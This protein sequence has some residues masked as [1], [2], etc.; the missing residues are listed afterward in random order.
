[1]CYSE[2]VNQNNTPKIYVEQ[3]FVLLHK[4]YDI[5]FSITQVCMHMFYS[6]LVLKVWVGPSS[7]EKLNHLLMAFE[8]GSF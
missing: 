1:M 8:A 3:G 4:M 6:H 7:Q 2:V 5:P